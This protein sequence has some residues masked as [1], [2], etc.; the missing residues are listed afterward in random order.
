MWQREVIRYA[1][2]IDVEDHSGYNIVKTGGC[3]SGSG[4]IS[5]RQPR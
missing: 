5:E 1:F 4:Q 2:L 3:N